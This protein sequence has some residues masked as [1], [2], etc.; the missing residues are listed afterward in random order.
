MTQDILHGIDTI[1][2]ENGLAKK[3][4]HG[5]T[6]NIKLGFDPTAPD[7]HLGHAV[8]LRKLRDFQQAGHNIIVIIGDFTARIGDPTGRNVT[9]PPL[10]TEQVMAN[11]DTYIAQLAKVLDITKIQIRFNA[12][13]FGKM[14][15]DEVI[16]LVSNVTLGQMMQRH[17]FRTRY[18][19]G[20]TIALHEMLY[21]VLQGYDSV[22]I[23]ADIE[24]GGTDQLF[25]CMVGKMIQD[26]LGCKN[27]QVV[28]CM[29]LLR[30][31]DGHEKMSKSKHNYIGL[32][33]DAE[34][35]F[36]KTM[37]IPDAL[38]IEYLELATSYSETEKANMKAELDSGNCNPAEIKKM[39]AR[40]IVT[41]YHDAAASE[42]AQL[43]FERK[44]QKKAF[45]DVDY[46]PRAL[47]ELGLT[48]DSTLLDACHAALPEKSRSEL[49]RLADGGGVKINGE[50][51][52]DLN[53]ALTQTAMPFTL[54]IG[55]RDLFRITA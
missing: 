53:T 37:S 34:N 10:T 40:N 8:V 51:V 1:V 48:P 5:K 50:K 14:G 39:I 4:A 54:Q 32:T 18:E 47:A 41:I 6:L 13:W 46:Q 19:E 21:P 12:E 25:N 26:A 52:S 24:I 17:D 31:T 29:P 44:V 45:S 30:G 11:A 49:R 9:R 35:M 55:K 36:G 23:D 33:E 38:L 3:L 43:A 28:V 7:L 2:P 20:R 15:F 22:V 27:S 16:K 42:A